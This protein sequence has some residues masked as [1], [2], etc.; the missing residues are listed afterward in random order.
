LFREVDLKQEF[1]RLLK[2]SISKKSAEGL[3]LSG[4]VDSS[5]LAVLASRLGPVTGVTSVFEGAPAGDVYY[6]SLVAKRLGIRHVLRKYDLQD[7]VLAIKEVVKITRSF[8]H[9]ALRNDVSIYL[10]LKACAEEGISYVMTGDGGDELF[11]GYE[12]MTKMSEGELSAY[13]D[14]ISENWTFSAPRLGRSLGL[15]VVQPYLSE[16]IINFAK[17]L[18]YPW[19]VR[20]YDGIHGKWI[21]RSVLEDLGL[22][23]IA[24]R[25]KEPIESGSGSFLLSKLLLER[26]GEEARELK[27]KAMEEGIRFW[28]DE[29]LYFYKVFRETVGKVPKAKAGERGCECCGA[30]LNSRRNHC[31]ICGFLNEGQGAG[32]FYGGCG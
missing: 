3:L 12:Y 8:D 6:S 23:E 28:S 24:R 16:K 25:R 2:D 30:P 26:L 15:E 1:L 19:K 9:V 27:A 22:P 20:R 11:A 5:L 14:F 18:P 13:I 10:S 17:R 4:G 31:A 7:A 21:L 32:D 29:Q